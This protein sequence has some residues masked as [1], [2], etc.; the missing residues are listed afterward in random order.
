MVVINA[1][2]PVAGAMS[3]LCVSLLFFPFDLRAVC[4]FLLG[5][6][7]SSCATSCS[8]SSCFLLFPLR[9]VLLLVRLVLLLVNF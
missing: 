9:L 7:A 6:S 3:A 5:L 8:A 1:S 2:F 4:K